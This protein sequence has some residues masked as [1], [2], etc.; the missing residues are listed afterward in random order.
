M[1]KWEIDCLFK[2]AMKATGTI[3][4]RVYNLYRGG[5]FFNFGWLGEHPPYDLNSIYK[6]DDLILNKKGG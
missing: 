3:P 5:V 6:N 1:T 2:R 4:A